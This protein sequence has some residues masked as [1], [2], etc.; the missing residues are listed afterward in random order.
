MVKLNEQ[1]LE[2]MSYNTALSA[3]FYIFKADDIITINLL[4]R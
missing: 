1:K 4:L 3:L 2:E